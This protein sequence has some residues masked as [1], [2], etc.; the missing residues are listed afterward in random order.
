MKKLLLTGAG[1]L[2]IVG[3]AVGCD[4]AQRDAGDAYQTVMSG[5]NHIL[6]AGEHV[7]FVT[8]RELCGLL[9][10]GEK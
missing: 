2:L 8:D 10:Q 3:A 5:G 6:K 4:T 7:V 9:P 1:L